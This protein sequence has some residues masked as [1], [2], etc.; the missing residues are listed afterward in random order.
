MRA[1]SLHNLLSSSLELGDFKGPSDG[2]TSPASEIFK[3][4]SK[5]AHIYCG[6]ITL[7]I[8]KG[9]IG[10]ET[11]FKLHL[12]DHVRNKTKGEQGRTE[13][14]SLSPISKTTV[15]EKKHKHNKWSLYHILFYLAIPSSFK[16]PLL[17]FVRQFG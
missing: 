10:M 3:T 8:S 6:L 14:G 17:Y 4:L 2:F 9:L 11:H 5:R 15:A 12:S 7:R 13:G 16:G 1:P